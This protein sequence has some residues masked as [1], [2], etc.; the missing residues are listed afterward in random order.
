ILAESFTSGDTGRLTG[1]R[2]LVALASAAPP[3]PAFF[4]SGFLRGLWLLPVVLDFVEVLVF[5]SF[6]KSQIPG[7][8][9][10]GSRLG[11]LGRARGP[12]ALLPLD[13]LLVT[14]EPR[15][16]DDLDHDVELL[17]EGRQ[18]AAVVVLQ[19]VRQL[20]MKADAGALDR[21]G[22]GAGLDAAE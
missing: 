1:S 10:D 21:A 13:S 7:F 14:V 17:F 5:P 6:G 22:G 12:F 3:P 11:L 4:S 18:L 20:R 19:R 8:Q 16:R 2:F 9:D 15:S